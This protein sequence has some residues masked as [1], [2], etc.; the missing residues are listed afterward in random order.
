MMNPA[1]PEGTF[2][3]GFV[4]GMGSGALMMGIFSSLIAVTAF[5][6][7]M[8][9]LPVIAATHGIGATL[10]MIGLGSVATGLFSGIT[11]TQRAAESVS[12]ASSASHPARREPITRGPEQAVAH[13]VAPHIEKAAHNSN[14]WTERVGASRTGTQSRVDQILADRNLNDGSR[15]AAILRDREQSDTLKASR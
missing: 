9:G 13:S 5:A 12:I 1:V 11:A 2:R 7:P 10:G 15:A 4:K 3:R 14:A 6:F 8:V